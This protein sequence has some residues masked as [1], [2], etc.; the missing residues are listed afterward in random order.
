M[1]FDISAV[2]LKKKNGHFND[3]FPK[4]NL[5]VKKFKKLSGTD[6]L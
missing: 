6:S 5:N 1:H 2:L 4:N 3:S